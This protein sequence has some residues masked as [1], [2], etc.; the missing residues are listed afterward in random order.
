MP[1]PNENPSQ[2]ERLGEAL[3]SKNNNPAG[4]KI[5]NGK[6][7]KGAKERANNIPNRHASAGWRNVWAKFFMEFGAR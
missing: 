1:T 3:R 4:A 2:N 6:I 5:A 7:L